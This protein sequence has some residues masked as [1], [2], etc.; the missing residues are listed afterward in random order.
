MRQK[1]RA[2]RTTGVAGG[3]LN[4]DPLE[5]RFIDDPP[6]HYRIE[7]DAARQAQVLFAR[8][9]M[10][11]FEQIENDVFKRLLRARRNV[12]VAFIYRLAGTARRAQGFERLVAELIPFG[13]VMIEHPNVDVEIVIAVRGQ[14]APGKE[15]VKLRLAVCGQ[16]HDLP[17]IAAEHVEA[18]QVRHGRIKLA[19]RMWKL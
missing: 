8:L 16:A 13:Q 10:Q 11:S 6:I 9:S 18:K 19:E 3:G 14:N 17:L 12:L 15:F 5:R 7:S 2:E 1:G 4:E